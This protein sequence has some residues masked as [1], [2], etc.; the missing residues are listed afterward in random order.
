MLIAEKL[1]DLLV[2]HWRETLCEALCEAVSFSDGAY[3]YSR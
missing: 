2:K 3:L 1:I